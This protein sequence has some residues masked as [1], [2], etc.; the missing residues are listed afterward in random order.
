MKPGM[1]KPGFG[2]TNLG[3]V[4]GAATGSIGGLF[5]VGIVPAIVYRD[6]TVLFHTPILALISWLTCIITGWLIGGQ[7]G[8]RLGMRLKSQRAESVGGCIGGLIPI[9]AIVLW[10]WYMTVGR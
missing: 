9:I 2:E 4:T 7:I 8:P 5:A 6:V 3:A 1:R 10:S